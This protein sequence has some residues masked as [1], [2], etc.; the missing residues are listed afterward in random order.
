M[1]VLLTQVAD[2]SMPILSFSIRT[3]RG[4][5]SCHPVTSKTSMSS[6]PR[7]GEALMTQSGSSGSINGLCAC[8]QTLSPLAPKPT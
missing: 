7:I 6:V 4:P 3:F 8:S 2:R 1:L 5:S